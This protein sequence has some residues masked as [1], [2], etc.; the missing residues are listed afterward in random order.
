MLGAALTLLLL[1][2]LLCCC[3]CC[4]CCCSY[5]MQV[6]LL[7][8]LLLLY[9]ERMPLLVHFNRHLFAC[10]SFEARARRYQSHINTVVDSVEDT[11]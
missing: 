5:I 1:L 8:L 9:F 10:Q 7:L 4:C 6:L 11:S 2:L 3:C